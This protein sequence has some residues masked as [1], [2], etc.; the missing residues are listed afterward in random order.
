MFEYEVIGANEVRII[1][2]ELTVPLPKNLIIPETTQ[3]NNITYTIVAIAA[4]VFRGLGLKRITLPDTIRVI[5][6]NAFSDNDIDQLTLPDQ[7]Q[8]I[9][10]SAFKNNYL[11]SI[12]ITPNLIAIDQSAFA[13]N[14][15]NQVKFNNQQ[16]VYIDEQAFEC[17]TFPQRS[18]INKGSTPMFDFELVDTSIHIIHLSNNHQN[19]TELIIP[20]IIKFHNIDYP[21]TCIEP[22]AFAN[23]Q[24]TSVLLPITLQRIQY[25]AFDHNNITNLQ[26]PPNITDIENAAFANNPIKNLRL[27]SKIRYVAPNA[28]DKQW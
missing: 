9:L 20:N 7:T 3:I 16:H 15:I 25:H 13:Q 21:V 26:L 24:L 14:N 18:L 28:F 4:S 10:N 27:P 11:T 8:Q 12:T 2:H 6:A 19:K 17:N 5:G 1:N 23:C 22:Y